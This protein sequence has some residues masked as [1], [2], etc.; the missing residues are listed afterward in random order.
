MIEV[1]EL[2]KQFGNI[3]AVGIAAARGRIVTLCDSDA[4]L[5]PTFVQSIID[6]FDFEKYPDLENFG[7]VLHCDEVRNVDKKFYPFSFPTFE[8]VAGEGCINWDGDKTTGL[9]DQEDSIHHRNYGACMSAL[10]EDLI[11]IGG[12]DEHL[13]YLGHICGPY[14]MTFRLVNDG[15]RKSGTPKNFYI[16]PG[17][18]EPTAKTITS[19]LMTVTTCLPPRWAH[20]PRKE[21]CPCRKTPSCNPS[22]RAEIFQTANNC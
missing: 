22:G 15:K 21:S 19:A 4:M 11:A 8:E 12:A 18:L 1:K 14:E 5:K 3:T 13:D 9:S 7:V 20:E 10:R 17:T 6:S 16:T 2:V